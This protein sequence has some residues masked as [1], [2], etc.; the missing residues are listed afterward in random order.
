MRFCSLLCCSSLKITFYAIVL[1][2]ELISA[3][4]YTKSLTCVHYAMVLKREKILLK[5]KPHSILR[6]NLRKKRL[7]V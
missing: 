7:R 3:T 6:R 2:N 5:F 1:L 4:D